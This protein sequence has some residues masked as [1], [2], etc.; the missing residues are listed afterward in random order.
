MSPENQPET[1]EK[2]PQLEVRHVVQLLMWAIRCSFARIT[3]PI[4]EKIFKK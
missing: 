1:L 4:V 3:G 2:R